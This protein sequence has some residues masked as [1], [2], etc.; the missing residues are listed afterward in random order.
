MARNILISGGE[1][2]AD[3][4]GKGSRGDVLI[5]DGVVAQISTGDMPAADEVIDASGCVVVPA[6]TDIHAHVYWGATS[7]GVRPEIAAHRSGTATFVDAGSAGAANILG[8]KEFIQHPSPYNILAYL[9]ISYPGIYGFSSRLMV[10]EGENPKLLNVEACV[11]AVREFADIIV[12]VKVR[13]GRLAA[14]DNGTEALRLGLEAAEQAGLPLMCHVDL[15]PPHIVDILNSLRPGDIVTHCCRPEPNA[16]VDDGRV[17]DAAWKAKERGVLFDIGHGMGGFSFAT[18][19]TMVEAGFVPDLVSSDIHCM[20]VDGPA[21]D[22]L[23]TMNKLLA[24]GVEFGAALAATTSRPAQIIGRPELGRIA[25]GDVANIAV[26]VR[27]GGRFPMVDVTG[28]EVTFSQA[29][30]CRHLISRGVPQAPHDTDH[31]Q[32]TRSEA[33]DHGN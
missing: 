8:F 29:L 18:C 21:Y 5:R 33:T 22:A 2:F 11:K 10:G 13:A 15:D 3:G 12:G 17:R 31:P 28:E 30:S 19:R 16:P 23:T 20:S 24:L 7:L 32:Q 1:I 27:D 9:N 6:L 25:V 14:G 4:N 26:L